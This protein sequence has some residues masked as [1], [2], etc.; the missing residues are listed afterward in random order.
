MPGGL[1]MPSIL[2]HPG[3][4]V[5]MTPGFIKATGGNEDIAET[6]AMKLLAR[7]VCGDFGV[8]CNEDKSSNERAILRGQFAS[9]MSV[10]EIPQRVYVITDPDREITTM[11]LPEEY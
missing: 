5:T 9:I 6:I 7:H 11:L 2:F 10:Y 8:I 1:F 4:S 3:Q